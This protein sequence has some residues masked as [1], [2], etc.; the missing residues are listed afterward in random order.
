MNDE[1]QKEIEQLENQRN[2]VELKLKTT[3][4]SNQ[5]LQVHNQNLI[6]QKENLEKE[7]KVLMDKKKE[8]E[9]IQV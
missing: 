3:G 9:N 4:Y 5:I 2:E 1:L 7:L 6:N 8:I